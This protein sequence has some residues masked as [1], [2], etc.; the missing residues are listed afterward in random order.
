MSKKLTIEEKLM[1]FL[2]SEY[3]KDNNSS[4]EISIN[5]TDIKDLGITENEASRT[6]LLLETSNYFTIKAK[7]VHN[8]FSRFWTVEL[9][10]FAI[11]YFDNQKE[12]KIEK[13]RKSFEEF[14]AWVTLLIAILA[15]GLSIYALYLQYM[16]TT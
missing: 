16:P 11:H 12:S 15:F 10:Q 13:R 4:N 5:A 7:S 6:L 1:Q 14:R 3:N 2:I 8:N 9:N